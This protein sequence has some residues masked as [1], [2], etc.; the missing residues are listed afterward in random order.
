[1][2]EYFI[3]TNS[4]KSGI[5]KKVIRTSTIIL[6]AIT[7]FLASGCK[8][9][10]P[11]S[12]IQPVTNIS[13]AGAKLNGKVNPKG[14]STTVTFEYGTTTSYNSSITAAQSPIKMEG[15]YDVS[16]DISGL[17]IGAIYH[18]R[19]KAENSHWTV[20]SRDLEF[21]YGHSPSV[22]TLAV[23]NSRSFGATLNGNVNAYG[24]PTIVTFE[25]GTT[26]SY[27]KE[28]T[29]KQNPVIGNNSANVSAEITGLTIGTTY[30]YRAKAENSFIT[31]YG[32]DIEFEYGYPPI[33]ASLEATNLTTTSTTLNGTVNASGLPTIVTF[34]YGTTTSYGQEITP[35]QNQVTGN[36]ITNVSADISGLTLCSTYHFRVKAENSFETVYSSDKEF[37]CGLPPVV[38]SLEATNLTSTTATL[39]G[40]VSA[41]S[42]SSVVTFQYGLTSGYGLEMTP[43]QNPVGDDITEISRDISDLTPCAIYHFRV[44]AE[45]SCGTSYGNDSTFYPPKRPAMTTIPIS[46]L[47]ATSVISGGIIIDDWCPYSPIADR[48]IELGRCGRGCFIWKII[49]VARGPEIS[50][51]P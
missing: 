2:R 18:Y 27:G 43:E 33:V 20:Y 37:K 12:S 19:V 26:K 1:M 10:E 21:E 3:K 8:E 7:F 45:N 49:H 36:S 48:G 17:T 40:Y 46:G 9:E 39:N 32:G 51:A 25:Y 24:L 50:L 42:S 41:N 38:A 16:A 5:M 11:E 22:T 35:A 30:H 23:K 13:I 6:A 31:V 29:S 15:I 28:V 4:S 44:K 47:T 34:E 14:L